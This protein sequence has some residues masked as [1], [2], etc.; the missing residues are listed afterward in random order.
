MELL[1]VDG[2][3][4]D[5]QETQQQPRLAPVEGNP[6][7]DA[8]MLGASPQATS[9][10]AVEQPSLVPV[11][12][13]PFAQE[14]TGFIEGARRSFLNT[15][16]EQNPESAAQFLEGIG[17]QVPETLKPGVEAGRQYFDS[18]RKTPD[19]ANAP[20]NISLKEVWDNSG[21]GFSTW[22]GNALGSAVAS[23]I[24]SLV[25][26]A[27]GAFGGSYVGPAGTVVGG[28]AGAAAGGYPLN[29]AEVY[30]ELKKN[31]VDPERAS[32][33]AHAAA[34]PM[35][36]LDSIPA[37]WAL[38]KFGGM[39]IIRRETARILATRLATEG[40]KGATI[41]AGT[42]GLQTAI[43]KIAQDVAAGVPFWSQD[44]MWDI[45]D[46]VGAGFV[47]GAAFGAATGVAR[48]QVKPKAASREELEAIVAG[49]VPGETTVTLDPT[50]QPAQASEIGF[51]P[52]PVFYSTVAKVAR[53]KLPDS[54]TSEQLMGTLQ[55]AP[56]VKPEELQY[57][58]VP[59]FAQ[60]EGKISKNDLM[61]H[62]EENA[63][64]IEDVT[65]SHNIPEAYTW[66]EDTANNGWTLDQDDAAIYAAENG[67]FRV[68]VAGEELG[69]YADRPQAENAVGRFL[70]ST[71]GERTQYSS[72]QAVKGG[73]NYRERLMRLP[74]VGLPS[75]GS[76]AAR[77]SKYQSAH[78]EPDNVLAHYRTADFNDVE[79]QRGM[80]VQ[81]IQSD[82]HQEGRKKGYQDGGPRPTRY[83]QVRQNP[84][85]QW[86][87]ESLDRSFGSR[88]YPTQEAAQRARDE[89]D[90]HD[91][92][93][94]RVPNAPFKTSW[95]ELAVK[96]ILR[97]AAD[98]GYRRV[99]L[100]P[101]KAQTELYRQA[102][103]NAEG[104][105]E[106]YDKILPKLFDKWAKKL[107]GKV[108][109]TEVITGY[110]FRDEQGRGYF[111]ENPFP[112]PEEIAA[113]WETNGAIPSPTTETVLYL[114]LTP[115]M[116]S[117]VQRGLP[118]FATLFES[119]DGA[120]KMNY[121]PAQNN[122]LLGYNR[123]LSQD[124]APAVEASNAIVQRLVTK[125]GIDVP[126]YVRIGS[127]SEYRDA[128][129]FMTPWVRNGKP[130]AYVIT[131]I[132]NMHND[133]STI[134]AT[135]AHE[136]GHIIQKEKFDKADAMTQLL[137][138]EE[139]HKYRDEIAQSDVSTMEGIF[140]RRDNFLVQAEGFRARD[141]LDFDP[142]QLRP[143]RREYWMGFEEW[144]AEN[145]A[146]WMTTNERAL[147]HVEK[148]FKSIATALRAMY[149]AFQQKT[150][151]L[152][153]AN[154]Q[155]AG[156]LEALEHQ[157]M[158]LAAAMEATNKRTKRANAAAL[159]AAGFSED[160][161]SEQT[162]QT[163]PGRELIKALVS[164]GSLS[165]NNLTQ[166]KATV[167]VA[168]HYSKW[169]KWGLS[170]IQLAE[171]N[172]HIQ[173]LFRYKEYWQQK[174]LERQTIM[175]EA[176]T[177][178]KAW[179]K[180]PDADGIAKLLD[181]Y[182][183]LEYLTPQERTAGIT[184]LPTPQE[185][186]TLAL[187]HKVSAEGMQLFKKI[188]K[189]FDN[190]LTRYEQVLNLDAQKIVEPYRRAQKL[191]EIQ[192]QFTALRK[193][194]YFPAMRFGNLTIEVRDAAGN[195]AEF[196]TFET[197]RSRGL[198]EVK[199][200]AAYPKA[201]GFDIRLGKLPEDAEPLMGIPPGFLDL[202]DQKLT[203]S[204]T[205][206]SALDVL[207]FQLSP[208]QSF[209][210][211]FERKN[212]VKGYSQDFQRAYANY[213]FHGSNHL[214][215]VKYIDQMRE[216][217]N[218]L[219][220]ESRGMADGTKRMEI[221]DFV[222]DHL[223]YM[224]NPTSDWSTLRALTFLWALG[225]SPAAALLNTTQIV[226]GSYP[227]LG[228]GFGD[229]KAIAALSSAGASLSSYYKKGTLK[230]LASQPGAAFEMR[231]IEE[232]VR[233]GIISEAMAAVLAALSEGNNL[234]GSVAGWKNLAF[235]NVMSGAGKMFEMTEQWNRRVTFRAALKLALDNPTAKY[236]DEAVAKN[237]L[238]YQRLRSAN[239]SEREARA[240]VTAKYAVESTQYIY[241][242]YAQPRLMR[243]KLRTVF[244]FKSFVQNTLFML[245]N[246]PAAAVRSLLVMALIG[247][248]MG[249]P[250]AED[251]KGLIKVIA[252]KLDSNF[253]ID[254]WVRGFAVDVLGGAI[255]PD[256]ILHGISRYGM[257][258]PQVMN[259]V[260]MP[261]PIMDMSRSVSMG[262]ILPIQ[263]DAA[264]GGGLNPERKMLDTVQ[265]A[266]GA[267]FGIGFNIWKG[268]ND[269]QQDWNSFARTTKMM[270]R[271]MQAIARFYQA[272][273]DGAIN[274]RNGVPVAR[275]DP[276][277]T[278][279]MM[280]MMAMAG[281]WQP[282]RL[283]AKWD[284]I[285][286]EREAIEYWDLR[287]QG[288]LRQYADAL[289]NRND[290]DRERTLSAIRQFNSKLPEAA[291]AKAITGDTLRRSV[292]T[293]ERIRSLQE[294]GIPAQRSNAGIVREIQRL[295]PE[296]QVDVRPTR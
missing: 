5:G 211:R 284:S 143:E 86:G 239:W 175:D 84:N 107:G 183:N 133:Y 122:E 240:F 19:A 160:L 147:T 254:D 195:L 292:T 59:E 164:S 218:D 245:W 66:T 273:R 23:S 53:E 83:G 251:L 155:I 47:G 140:Q 128:L 46:S 131:M 100:A 55:N 185:E 14:R 241:S 54:F 262:N 44:N 204:P 126:V 76:N 138:L 248:M 222:G 256:L 232:A 89:M 139:Y 106:F 214:T 199:L 112:S 293:R 258:I 137:M 104:Q 57:L 272:Y 294:Q 142:R 115:K 219:R 264:L 184:R 18:I 3:P 63:I 243:G 144:F 98:E 279:H 192:Q 178:I 285:I 226:V 110:H 95:A 62:L 275:F 26:G 125:F 236:V 208:A 117:E 33:V 16:F 282:L 213:F 176:L 1:P 238:Q 283:T 191:R 193:Q 101:G 198:G 271:Q 246:N 74:N 171:R 20:D 260:G 267:T 277:D 60:R 209:K 221:A 205:Q 71:I 234:Q 153:D 37:A 109:K 229:V 85:G 50:A 40:A 156:F 65:Y 45:A 203:L 190:M 174:T 38:T 15:T 69:L 24:P 99:Y 108:G 250:G 67:G 287:R 9:V 70:E 118:M 167:A 237:D 13:N 120:D 8:P 180:S 162:T 257:G 197:K 64:R 235:M 189:D 29:Y 31:G 165:G 288:L 35:A 177:T 233:E 225:F 231:A 230:H 286:A 145:V 51:D 114:D 134:Y 136:F 210:H 163:G 129:G 181:D 196:Q 276:H 41:E 79:G 268:I 154:E 179:R 27:A 121:V 61:A 169:Y 253:D 7:T 36:A 244:I 82:W 270:P 116:A 187:N 80:L 43:N 152:A 119:I 78:W 52:Q 94:F 102:G 206:R 22:A 265:R 105:Q 135:V 172:P 103:E 266:S 259:W 170:V 87:W 11:E 200:R 4:F 58:K 17:Y 215:R 2:N 223:N 92:I 34:I 97:Q 224:L 281:G 227:I 249:L 113:Q 261:A 124:L 56:G 290:E 217:V 132:P 280:E 263:L 28:A 6:F 173:S 91:S 93:D 194:P 148:L 216:V 39:G 10:G 73:E 146:R 158:N 49:A 182:M 150:G 157:E 12:G 212:R 201:Q 90:R 186:A 269:S 149:A 151:L 207:K 296:A 295:H 278:R 247:G 42:E 68:Y 21:E 168:D 77:D 220:Q 188:Q 161:A 88:Q 291:R 75:D 202:I 123:N 111:L 166:A 30:K 242:Q 274:N 159:R 252:K 289:R 130:I 25:T 141:T 96:R 72:W 48:D 127:K 228:A 255:S 81:E 32:K